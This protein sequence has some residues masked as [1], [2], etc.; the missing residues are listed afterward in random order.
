MPVSLP[1]V[2]HAPLAVIPP[3][4]SKHETTNGVGVQK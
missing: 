1:P 3:L 4:K 2:Q